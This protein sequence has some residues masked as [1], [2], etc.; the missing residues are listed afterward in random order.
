MTSSFSEKVHES[1]QG[2]YQKWESSWMKNVIILD[3]TFLDIGKQKMF[4]LACTFV[5]SRFI[6]QIPIKCTRLCC[7]KKGHHNILPAQNW[8]FKHKFMFSIV[9]LW[10]IVHANLLSLTVFPPLTITHCE[11]LKV[12]H[13]DFKTFMKLNLHFILMNIKGP[14]Y[15]MSF[16][17][18]RCK[19]W[20]SYTPFGIP[21]CL[22]CKCFPHKKC[23]ESP[24]RTGYPVMCM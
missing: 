18:T 16:A 21:F 23:G 2:I 8:T 6:I 9:N 12:F 19:R 7:P 15:T 3:W 1:C 17:S 22:H 5:I 11:R 24:C 13:N 20:V 4:K 10:N 14:L